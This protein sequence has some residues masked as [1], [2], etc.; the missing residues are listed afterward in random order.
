MIVS[1]ATD[2]RAVRAALTD[3]AEI[4]PFFELRTEVG[5]EW[6]PIR[7]LLADE[8]A[9]S[10]QV[11]RVAVALD[12]SET[13]VA[14]S[15]L[16]QDIAARL[17]SPVIAATAAYSIVPDLSRLRCLTDSGITLGLAEA[18]GSRP[19]ERSVELVYR[20]VVDGVL[21]PLITA[22]RRETSLSETVFWGNA[23]SALVGVLHVLRAVQPQHA[24]RAAELVREL[25]RRQRLSK[26]GRVDAEH[27]F[28]RHSCCLYYRVS[29]GGL[30]GDCVLAHRAN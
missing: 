12:T 6:R 10:A 16:Q 19:R 5:A 17:W 9:L 7:E 23:G 20:E 30:C 13:G 2:P 21:A 18:S 22:L 25:L 14:A 1:E 26:A 3:V 11:R 24:D 28:V 8:A 15:I 4:G 29:G 27:G